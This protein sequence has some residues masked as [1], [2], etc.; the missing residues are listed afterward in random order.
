MGKKKVIKKKRVEK[1]PH[2]DLYHF[3]MLLKHTVKN[4][5]ND[6][7]DIDDFFKKQAERLKKQLEEIL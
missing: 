5:K 2:P 7:T 4:I 6:G 3:T 1:K